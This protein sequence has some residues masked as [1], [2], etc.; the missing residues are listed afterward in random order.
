MLS[1]SGPCDLAGGVLLPH[2]LLLLLFCP[3][4]ALRSVL[5]SYLF[6]LP[7]LISSFLIHMPDSVIAS[8]LTIMVHTRL[9]IAKSPFFFFFSMYVYSF[10]RPRV[11]SFHHASTPFRFRT[12]K[13]QQISP[14]TRIILFHAY[15]HARLA[16]RKCEVRWKNFGQYR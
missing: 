10:V 15:L 7:D 5:A 13:I 8:C 11:Q 9:R 14:L 16:N 12:G 2:A 4:P 1:F 6:P 3:S